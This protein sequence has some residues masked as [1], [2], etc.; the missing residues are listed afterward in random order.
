[1][2]V[3][4]RSAKSFGK[5]VSPLPLRSLPAR[6]S[7]Q[8]KPAAENPKVAKPPARATAVRLAAEVERLAAELEASRAR[9]SELET[10]ID[11]DPLTEALNRHGFER[12]LKRSL[13]Y[14]KRYGVSAALVWRFK[15]P[16]HFCGELVMRTSEP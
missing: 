10:R 5:A 4:N 2:P 3:K 6:E 15:S 7:I 12:E 9:I 11:V 16:H 8:R 13:A 1:M 14:V